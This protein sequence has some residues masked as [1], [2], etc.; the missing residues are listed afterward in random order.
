MDLLLRRGQRKYKCGQI[1]NLEQ[2]ILAKNIISVFVNPTVYVRWDVLA[3]NLG[4]LF[5]VVDMLLVL[6]HTR[7]VGLAPDLVSTCSGR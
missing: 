2:Y 5:A 6:L 7:L 3:A 1:T 4:P